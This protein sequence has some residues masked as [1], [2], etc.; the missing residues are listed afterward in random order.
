MGNF[1]IRAMDI[2]KTTSFVPHWA[3]VVASS[4]AAWFL[5]LIMQ[6][7]SI[8]HTV[9]ATNVTC[10]VKDA[11]I[12]DVSIQL[13]IDCDGHQARL[14]ST[15]LVYDLVSQGAKTVKCEKLYEDNSIGGC[16]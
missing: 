2:L 5:V 14:A 1:F 9:I 13:L 8:S 3:L 11:L 7:S 10:S 6:K 12:S 4:F 16:E 15:R